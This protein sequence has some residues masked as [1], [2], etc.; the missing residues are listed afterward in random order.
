MPIVYLVQMLLKQLSEQTTCFSHKCCLRCKKKMPPGP[1]DTSR[2]DVLQKILHLLTTNLR[3][4]RHACSRVIS[5]ANVVVYC[6]E[7]R[8]YT[9]RTDSVIKQS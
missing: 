7:A 6:W 1:I 4:R 3:F 8:C 2:N 9:S 5:F